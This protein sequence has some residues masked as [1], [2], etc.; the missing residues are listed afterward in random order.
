[1]L[2]IP[3]KSKFL[4]YLNSIPYLFPINPSVPSRIPLHYTGS[5]ASIRTN[6]FHLT[7]SINPNHPTLTSKMPML[8]SFHFFKRQ[9]LN[10]IVI[11]Q[12]DSS[13]ISMTKTNTDL[14]N[15]EQV[16]SFLW[17]TSISI[18]ALP[19]DPQIR[20]SVKDDHVQTTAIISRRMRWEIEWMKSIFLPFAIDYDQL[21]PIN[22]S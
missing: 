5:I 7:G 11:F 15:L 8:K 9:T 6:P 19:K 20:R 4:L 22:I 14:Q 18:R 1:M 3:S 10:S 12:S 21:Y 16:Q 13:S 2:K 17:V